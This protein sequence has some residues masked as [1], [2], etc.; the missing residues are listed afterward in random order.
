MVVRITTA[1]TLVN[2]HVIDGRCPQKINIT[3][4]TAAHCSRQPT[5]VETDVAVI[6]RCA[7]FSRGRARRPPPEIGDFVL[8]GSPFAEPFGHTRIIKR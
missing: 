2:R 8:L 6:R 7:R 3:W 4:L 5:D 1:T